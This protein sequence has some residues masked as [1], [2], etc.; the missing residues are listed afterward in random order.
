MQMTREKLLRALRPER[1]LPGEVCLRPG[2][3]GYRG[4]QR[5]DSRGQVPPV[6]ARS[7]ILAGP[8]FGR[9]GGLLPRRRLPA[10]GAQGLL[11]ALDGG[12]HQSQQQGDPLLGPG[13]RRPA[14]AVFH[15]NLE[16]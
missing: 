10:A 12:L 5:S 2:L 7:E 1:R 13:V 3:Y 8:S 16:R 14:P 11:G 4:A 9:A 6:A 15:G